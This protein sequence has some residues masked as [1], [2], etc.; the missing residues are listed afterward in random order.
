MGYKYNALMKLKN[1]KLN[2]HTTELA[3]C[4]ADILN[5]IQKHGDAFSVR[6]DSNIILTDLPFYTDIND[7]PDSPTVGDSWIFSN[8]RKYDANQL[9]NFVATVHSDGNFEIE[10]SELKIPLRHMYRY[11]ESLSYVTGNICDKPQDW[12]IRGNV[13]IKYVEKCIYFMFTRYIFERVECTLYPYGVGI[14][15]EPIVFWQIG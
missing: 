4:K 14:F 1:K 12:K 15:N 9:L 6:E 13:N 11:P 2:I 5:L 10:S 8:G 7:I 3:Y